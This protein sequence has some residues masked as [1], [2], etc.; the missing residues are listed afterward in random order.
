VLARRPERAADVVPQME[1]SLSRMSGLIDD[2]MDFARGR[3]G[4][5]M[6]LK[7][8]ADEPLEPTL[9][10][11]VQELQSTHPGR[12]V[13]LDIALDEPVRCD[14]S[15]IAQLLSNLLGN[16]L[17]YGGAAEPVRIMASAAGGVF[18]LAVAN[19]GEPIPPAAMERLF[20]PFFR[21]EV[22]RSDEGLGLGL[23]IAAEIARAHGGQLGVT[24][25]P[26]ETCFTLRMPTR[27]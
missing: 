6:M 11:V 12:R 2:V 13:D 20:Q 8:D 18:V 17:T 1:Q 5:G 10:Q 3:L 4:S 27:A 25:T 22:R 26:A 24:S 9:I 16:A 7:L 14:R 15:R 23:Y 19:G 21:G